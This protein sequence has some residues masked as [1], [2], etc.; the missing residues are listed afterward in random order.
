MR[1]TSSLLLALAACAPLGAADIAPIARLTAGDGVQG[2]RDIVDGAP[3]ASGDHVARIELAGG[4]SGTVLLAPHASV[5]LAR[6][7]AGGG[8]SLRVDLLQGRLVM[9]LA[10]RGPYAD[11]HVIGGSTDTRVVGTLFLV[12]HGAHDKDYVAVMHGHVSVRLRGDV[13][14]TVAGGAHDHAELTDREG[15]QGTL[16]G[17]GEV[18]ALSGHPVVDAE[19]VHNQGGGLDVPPIDLE[20]LLGELGDLV[21]NQGGSLDLTPAEAAIVAHLEQQIQQ[22]IQQ[23]VTL[24]VEN[25]TS[26]GGG[27]GSG[28]VNFGGP[29]AP[30]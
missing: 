15:V 12:E 20:L 26:H 25:T 6:V 18:D 19:K 28:H 2:P 23:Q 17:M 21:I 27:G 9:D 24:E 4:A 8:T 10:A 7:S 29:P 14:T 1:L 11:V 13:T 5:T 22:Q 3:V 16:N 30:P